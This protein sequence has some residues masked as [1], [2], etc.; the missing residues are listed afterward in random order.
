[1]NCA[2][3][4][5]SQ[6]GTGIFRL[7]I[8]IGYEQFIYMRSL[9]R[10]MPAGNPATCFLNHPHVAKHLSDCIK[11]V[12]YTES[13]RVLTRPVNSVD[14]YHRHFPKDTATPF[15]RNP[16]NRDARLPNPR[17]CPGEPM[18]PEIAQL[19]GE[20]RQY[21]ARLEAIR[22]EVKI[23]I[24]GQ[25]D[26]I[27]R[28][29]LALC[30][31]G[32]VLLEGVPGIAKTLMIRTLSRTIDSSFA[33][34][35]FTPDLLPADIMGTR[36]FSQ[37]DERFSTVRGPIFAHFVLADEINRAPPKVQSALL[38]AMQE[39]Q[40]TIQGETHP[41][42]SPFFVLA[43][44]N[45]IESE[46]TYPLPE[47]QVDRFMFKLLMGYPSKDEE[48]RILDRFTEGKEN[49]VKVVTGVAEILA[50]QGFVKKI[51]ADPAI[52]HYVAELVDATRHP[53]VYGIDTA[54]FVAFGA[55]PRASICLVLGAKAHAMTSG[56]GYVIPEDVRAIAHD[57][58][59]HRILLTYEGEA[60]RVTPD[61]IIDRILSSVKVP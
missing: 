39:K 51:Y 17:Q 7:S 2:E 18:N 13:D 31:D 3:F 19:G 26:T 32:H 54:H 44:Q 37:R 48:V 14:R 50:L 12:G 23:V 40:V 30:A 1:M 21:A 47:A 42:P 57:V 61:V 43:T 55:S 52:K 49:D 20:A 22:S 9:A 46:G 16:E 5:S 59:R 27:D 38:E 11:T 35:Q 28:L 36:I 10:H 8:Y 15:L 24:V 25:G 6:S 58:L 4:I 33:R 29:L 53:A 34:L 45:P 60:E 41:L 56:R